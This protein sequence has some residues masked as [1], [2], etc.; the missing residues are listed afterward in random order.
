MFGDL[1]RFKEKQ[2]FDENKTG[3][4]ILPD[5]SYDLEIFACLLTDAS[6]DAIFEPHE[7][8]ADING[9]LDFTEQT[10]L[11]YDANTITRLRETN[12]QEQILILSTCSAE[13]TDARTIVLTVMKPHVSKIGG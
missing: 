7:Y 10:A 1:D 5:R 3:L 9:L 4:L 12:G 2:F 11:Y 8:K 13:F 6:E